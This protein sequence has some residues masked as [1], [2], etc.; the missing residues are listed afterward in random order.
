MGDGN[1]FTNDTDI[2]DPATYDPLLDAFCN[3]SDDQAEV[4]SD[5][6]TT[7]RYPS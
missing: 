3:A 1:L 6:N 4:C 2:T 7:S 5:G